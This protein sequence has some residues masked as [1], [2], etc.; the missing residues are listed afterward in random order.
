[1]ISI[2]LIFSPQVK[3]AWEQTRTVEQNLN[4]MGLAYDSNK[5]LKIPSSKELLL[6]MECDGENIKCDEEISVP[7]KTYVAKGLEEDAKAPRVKNFRLP[8]N[9]ITWLTYLMD[10]YEDDYKAMAKD[11]KNY[12][13]ETW[14]QI[15]NKIKKFKNIPEQ[16]D[17][18]MES[19]K[20]QNSVNSIL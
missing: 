14:R 9:Q 13:Q 18:Y 12:Y 5:A 15:R 17:M 2:N 8:N 1:M 4:D 10:K 3:K 19:R 11:P 6:P 20:K 16:Y 7:I